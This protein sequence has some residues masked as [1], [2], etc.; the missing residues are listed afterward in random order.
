[1]KLCLPAII[2]LVVSAITLVQTGITEFNV[3]NMLVQIVFLILWTWLI[4][5]LCKNG[6]FIT[7]WVMLIISRI[8]IDHLFIMD[9]IVY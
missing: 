4:N 8:K 9:Y 7:S 6:Y 5:Y 3:E 2:C 1:M